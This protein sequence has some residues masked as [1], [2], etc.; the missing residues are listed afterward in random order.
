MEKVLPEKSN[1][2]CLTN[3][4][5]A[6]F[7]FHALRSC[8]VV[9]RRRGAMLRGEQGGR[10]VP[11]C[12]GERERTAAE[13]DVATRIGKSRLERNWKT[14]QLVREWT[15]PAQGTSSD[16]SLRLRTSLREGPI[17]CGDAESAATA[18]SLTAPTS[19]A[20]KTLCEDCGLSLALPLGKSTSWHRPPAELEY[21]FTRPCSY[22]VPERRRGARGE[23]KV[24]R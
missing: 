15:R 19:H 13:A 7:H 3:S 14:R 17:K 5:G 8:L 16:L 10:A 22:T 9:T 11:V 24:A 6:R 20:P 1:C 21:H 12:P 23:R 18:V 4:S 2:D